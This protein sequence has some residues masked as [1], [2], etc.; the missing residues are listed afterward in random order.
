MAK[1]YWWNQEPKNDIEIVSSTSFAPLD[2]SSP[3]RY[4]LDELD[5]HS[6]T[7]DLEDS[8]LRIPDRSTQNDNVLK[9]IRNWPVPSNDG[10]DNL[11]RVEAPGFGN[12]EEPVGVAMV[13]EAVDP[14][15]PS[16][17]GRQLKEPVEPAEDEPVEPAS[18]LRSRTPFKIRENLSHL[19]GWDKPVD[20][21]PEYEEGVSKVEITAPGNKTT[22]KPINN[23]SHTCGDNRSKLKYWKPCNRLGLLN[24]DQYSAF[25]YE[26]NLIKNHIND[27]PLCYPW[28]FWITNDNKTVA[29]TVIGNLIDLKLSLKLIKNI[30]KESKIMIFKLGVLPRRKTDENVDSISIDIQVNHQNDYEAFKEILQICLDSTL[31]KPDLD[32]MY[33]DKFLLPNNY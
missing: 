14:P 16:P 21:D 4:L 25:N 11:V 3:K 5:N 33:I 29:N 2:Q 28:V 9:T 27:F 24:N 15:S 22:P 18:R 30:Y 10:S 7:E 1:R 12:G 17:R 19:F 23:E 13:T 8:L 26:L 6:I 32:R 31:Y 20:P